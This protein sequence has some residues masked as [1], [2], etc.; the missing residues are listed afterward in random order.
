MNVMVKMDSK[1]ALLKEFLQRL[2]LVEDPKH[3]FEREHLML[4]EEDYAREYCENVAEDRDCP[5]YCEDACCWLRDHLETARR[6]VSA[7]NRVIDALVREGFWGLTEL[8][9]YEPYK[10]DECVRHATSWYD[11]YYDAE[12]FC[13]GCRYCG[14]EDCPDE[15]FNPDCARMY[16]AY[17][18]ER[19][20]DAVNELL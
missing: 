13:G 5:N 3:T 8:V 6:I 20:T 19:V 12:G 4:D 15:V 14:T 16:T 18:I 10:I 1:T 17:A 11:G 9:P 7:G 2:S